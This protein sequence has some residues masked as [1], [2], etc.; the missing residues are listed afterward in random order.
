LQLLIR[1][2]KVLE[3]SDSEMKF[4][5]RHRKKI[6]AIALLTL[7]LIVIAGQPGTGYK[8]TDLNLSQGGVITGGGVG[9]GVTI[10]RLFNGHIQVQ[11]NP[12]LFPISYLMGKESVFRK[13]RGAAEFWDYG[14]EQLK[15][16]VTLG[17]LFTE[18][19][20]NLPYFLATSLLATL[21]AVKLS[22]ASV[23]KRLITK[24]KIRT[25]HL[26]VRNSV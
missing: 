7:A 13:F 3:Q 1:R 15:E 18:L 20:W 21:L 22:K 11:F 16:A 5:Y 12:L 2:E 9:N 25:S 24:P 14:G 23:I 8:V 26:P 17:T 6:Y 4:T 10:N 19:V